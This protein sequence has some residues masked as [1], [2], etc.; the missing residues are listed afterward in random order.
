[1]RYFEIWNLNAREHDRFLYLNGILKYT[2]WYEYKVTSQKCSFQM[3]LKYQ[4]VLV[5]NLDSHILKIA[6][7]PGF[8]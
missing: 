1:M 6:N 4:L 2:F 7:M 8:V 3:N 5:D